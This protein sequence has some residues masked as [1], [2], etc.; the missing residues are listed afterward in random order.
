M[1]LKNKTLWAIYLVYLLVTGVTMSRH[2][3]WGDEVHSWNI[4]KASNTYPELIENRRFEGHPPGWYTILW[5]ISRFT[6][7]TAYMQLVQ[8]IIASL[9]AA[10][11]IFYS[12]FP[13]STKALFCFGYYF[14]YEYAILSRNYAIGVLITCCICLLPVREFRFKTLVYYLL[15][16]C[17]SNVHLLAMLL[18][19]S[20]H[21]YFLLSYIEQKRT[22]RQILVHAVAGGIVFLPAVYF[23]F[24]PSDST[25]NM[26]Y[27]LHRWNIHQLTATVEGPLRAFLP[28]PAW[29][30]PHFWN[31]QFLIEAKPA[32]SSLKVVNLLLAICFPLAAAYLLRKSWKALALFG[33]NFML[34]FLLS[35]GMFSLTSARYA[36]FIFIGFFAACWL[37]YYDQP[38]E[39][40]NKKFLHSLLVI[41]L[42]AAIY[43][44][45]GDIR[46]PFSNLY[47]IGKLVDEVPP[48]QRLVTDYWTMNGYV[49]YLDKPAYCVD[50]D[51]SI[52]F[53]TWGPD[54]AAMQ[55]NSHR[56]T[57]GLRRY[58]DREKV[59]D[60]YMVT[61]GSP[62]QMDKV[63]SAFSS[64]FRIQLIDS[65]TG[66]IEKGSD[67]YLYKVTDTGKAANNTNPIT[68]NSQAR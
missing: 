7:N 51:M 4:S 43:F 62:R 59:K 65:L 40:V 28:L 13:L 41:Q 24:P 22:L 21:L 46:R 20:L 34:N 27:W 44:V 11:I 5:S 16:F 17:L 9:V 12:P 54:M 3:L 42:L 50:M 25:I 49:A 47:R 45:I 26:G 68:V 36:G 48:G 8:W 32:H 61:L 39:G 37:H 56:Y 58:F 57:V 6:H 66:A 67:L 35:A 64:S 2:E 33:T 23:I 15:L 1:A 10:L 30:N 29:W 38:I 31:T 14:L 19:A 60:T 52:S 18:A 53:V 55:G 63:D